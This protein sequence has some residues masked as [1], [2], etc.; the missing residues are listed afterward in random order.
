MDKVLK[1]L[2]KFSIAELEQ[3]AGP[4]I[5]RAVKHAYKTDSERELAKL[6]LDRYGFN[7]FSN[8]AVR[9]RF[10]QL[11]SKE[12][13]ELACKRI[14]LQFGGAQDAYTVLEDRFGNTY[15][16]NKSLEFILIFDLPNEYAPIEEKDNRLEKEI[17]HSQYGEILKSKGVLH[18]YQIRVK[19]SIR[20]KIDLGTKRLIVQMPTGAGKT[21]TALEVISD[22]VRGPDFKGFSVWIVDSNE[23]AD[24][25]F[26]SF[27]DLWKLRG[28]RPINA[29][30]YFKDFTPDF[31]QSSP[32]I[33]FAS[34]SKTW[35]AIKSKNEKDKSNF[36]ELCKRS[37]L[38]IVDEAHTSVADTYSTTIEKLVY[39]DA[40][41]VGL[42]ATPGRNSDF[43]TKDLKM[44]YGDELVSITDNQG[45]SIADEISFLQKENYL[46]TINFENFDGAIVTDTEVNT[47]CKNLA[48]N[49]ARN[50]KIINQIQKAV[51]LKQSTIVFACTVDHVIALMA[52]CRSKNINAD[53]IIGEV[54]QF[55]RIKIMEKFRRKD[56]MVIINHEML[57]TGI[58]LPNVDKLIITRPVGS[59]IL[60]SQILGRALRGLR[61]GGNESNIVVNI[62]DN[63]KNFPSASYIFNSFKNNFI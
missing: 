59:P 48:E 22:Y 30:R 3:L 26:N 23:L 38:V 35:A 19:D 60:Y 62:N 33:V 13:A 57:S 37:S 51:D 15:T 34:F 25:A 9:L 56:L 29:Y 54:P 40:C 24:Q 36:H 55:R 11:L 52:L 39:F 61:N 14:N 27:L 7:I 32:G 20:K 45:N 2:N 18:P 41:L 49:S 17:I 43:E 1:F 44:M 4:T 53:F 21:F 46:A 6:V 28:D 12:D 10:I 58:D 31:K 47:I 50:E 42:S 8:G 5:V 16:R 63:L